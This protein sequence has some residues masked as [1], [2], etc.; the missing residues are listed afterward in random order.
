MVIIDSLLVYQNKYY[1]QAYLDNWA[2]KIID[3]HMIDY[4]DGNLFF[5]ILK[6]ASYK[7]F[8]MIDWFKQRN[9]CC[10]K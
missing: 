4:L 9:W 5:L 7:F 3:K 6:I 1:L 2:Y 10:W 8:I